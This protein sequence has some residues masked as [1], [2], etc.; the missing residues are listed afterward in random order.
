MATLALRPMHTNVS[1]EEKSCKRRPIGPSGP[2]S[3]TM[4]FVLLT[5][6]IA[7]YLR[8]TIVRL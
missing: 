5:E 6:V 7:I 3:L 2:S 1:A 4:I 8:L